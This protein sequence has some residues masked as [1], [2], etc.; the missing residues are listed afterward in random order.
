MSAA[1]NDTVISL[2]LFFFYEGDGNIR[3]GSRN[4]RDQNR[5][6]VEIEFTPCFP[7]MLDKF[8]M[9]TEGVPAPKNK[10]KTTVRL[11][12]DLQPCECVYKLRI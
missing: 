8:I 6:R 9:W 4:S 10:T 7:E 5:I 2:F 12:L 3:I 11:I 1:H